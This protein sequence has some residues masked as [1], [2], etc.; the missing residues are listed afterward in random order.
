MVFPVFFA[1]PF[2]CSL[3]FSL[4][5]LPLPRFLPQRET[6]RTQGLPGGSLRLWGRKS[7]TVTF[8]AFLLENWQQEWLICLGQRSWWWGDGELLQSL[9]SPS[10][11]SGWLIWNYITSFSDNSCYCFEVRLILSTVCARPAEDK[12]DV[13]AFHLD[14]LRP[15]PLL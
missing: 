15:Y 5:C 9:P 3:T 2:S 1:S 4:S 7:Y 14:S 6:Q 8:P 10:F 13:W 12:P 11:P